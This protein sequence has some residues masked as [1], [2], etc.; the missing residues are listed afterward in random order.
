[1]ELFVHVTEELQ[2][3]TAVI[4]NLFLKGKKKGLRRL[5]VITAS[6]PVHIKVSLTGL[7]SLH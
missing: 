7:F 5:S 2:G 3:S 1:M 4:E 6:V